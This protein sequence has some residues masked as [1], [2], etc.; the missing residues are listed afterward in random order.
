MSISKEDN[1]TVL[2]SVGVVNLKAIRVF[3]PATVANMICGFDVLG[4]AVDA[5][6]DEVF[7][8]RVGSPG[9]RIRS[10]QGD[11]GRLPL[12]ASKNTVSASVGLLLAHL[13]LEQEI[14]LEIELVKHMPI[15]SGLGSSS[16]STSCRFICCKPFARRA[17]Y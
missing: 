10:I 16:A 7:M 4:F 12:D 13:G 5:P 3:A 6:G 1:K 2:E 11:Q 9:V 17:A 14:G 15:G 8:E